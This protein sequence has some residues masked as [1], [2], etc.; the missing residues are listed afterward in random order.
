MGVV[1]A[2]T[3]SVHSVFSVV[4]K[5]SRRRSATCESGE[6]S[7]HSRLRLWF[8]GVGH[9]IRAIRAIRGKTAVAVAVT[10]SRAVLCDLCTLCGKRLG[11][12]ACINDGGI[13]DH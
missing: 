8:R 6:G 11:A 13:V 9:Y 4:E 10:I 1:V 3:I 12:S 5:P 2:V 7:P